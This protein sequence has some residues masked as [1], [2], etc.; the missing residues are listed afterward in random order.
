MARKTNKIEIPISKPDEFVKLLN[1][2]SAKNK[3]LGAGSPLKA[4]AQFTMATYDAKMAEA[5]A[6]RAK[7]EELRSQSENAMEKARLLYGTGKEQN[8]NTS[9]TLYNMISSIKTM[10]M[11]QN[12][13]NEEALSEWGFQVV[14]KKA[15]T[16]KKTTPVEP[17]KP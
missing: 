8:I 4:L 5:D 3:A 1:K 9:G 7:A 2:V 13:G 6:L 12:K 11:V 10:L 15:S 14:V 17:P 16:G